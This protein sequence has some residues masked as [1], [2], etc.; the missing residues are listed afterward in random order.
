MPADGS[1]TPPE[2]GPSRRQGA[3]P[4]GSS[5]AGAGPALVLYADGAA[6][7]NP[8]PAGLGVVLLDARGRVLR[9]ASESLGRMTNNQAEYRALIRGLELAT[10]LGAH[11]LEVRLDSEL[12]VRQLEG[13][14]RVRNA[15]LRPLH[16]RAR[17]LL[18]GFPRVRLRH[19]PRG[20]NEEADRL[21]SQAAAREAG[22]R[23]G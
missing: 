4:A 7:G 5:G 22:R 14:Y 18:A 13:R 11:S 20:G 23:P 3:S 6:R 2:G 8:G 21:A 10:E 9:R 17:A 19:V 16:E 15:A 1:S 12:L